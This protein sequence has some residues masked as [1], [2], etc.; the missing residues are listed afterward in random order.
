MAELDDAGEGVVGQVAET[1]GDVEP[2]VDDVR[3]LI[4]DATAALYGF[5]GDGQ[6]RA[7]TRV[8]PVGLSEVVR[9][10]DSRMQTVLLPVLREQGVLSGGGW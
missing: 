1:H 10:L 6:E 7:T 3:V 9:E 4:G 8:P 2:I 5:G